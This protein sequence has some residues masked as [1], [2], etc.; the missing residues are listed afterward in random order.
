[1]ECKTKYLLLFFLLVG[2]LLFAQ[3][4]LIIDEKALQEIPLG[5]YLLYYEDKNRNLH[6]EQI[7]ADTFQK[8]FKPFPAEI[9][10]LGTSKAAVWLKLQ[11]R[12]QANRKYYLYINHVSLDSAFLYTPTPA[13]IL[14]YE[15]FKAG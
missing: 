10:S 12:F 7:S 15:V 5:E 3:E 11:L 4:V 8:N 1:M 6:I 13:N 9:L 14:Q 2:K